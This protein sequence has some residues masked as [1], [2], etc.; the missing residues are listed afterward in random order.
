MTS[1][2]M[3]GNDTSKTEL[4]FIVW[5]LKVIVGIPNIDPPKTIR[6]LISAERYSITSPHLSL[7]TLTLFPFR[8]STLKP[9]HSLKSNKSPP[10]STT[11]FYSRHNGHRITLQIH[12]FPR[13]VLLPLFKFQ[14]S[15]HTTILFPTF[16]MIYDRAIS[17]GLKHSNTQTLASSPNS[18]LHSFPSHFITFSLSSFL[19]VPIISISILPPSFLLISPFLLLYSHFVSIHDFDTHL[20][21]RLISP[22]SPRS[23][24]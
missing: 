11:R 2:V 23:L 19:T 15:L 24:Q 17:G 9:D 6:F 8:H 18:F 21:T 5:P 14:N 1:Q 4:I 22:E 7:P 16:S 3:S 10:F 13:I 12:S 20:L